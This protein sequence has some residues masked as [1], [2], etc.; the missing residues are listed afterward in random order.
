MHHVYRLALIHGLGNA[1]VILFGETPVQV[2]SE[3][4]SQRAILRER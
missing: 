4:V 3:L 1:V 2:L